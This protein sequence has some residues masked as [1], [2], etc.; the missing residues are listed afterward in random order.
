MFVNAFQ[1]NV[2]PGCGEAVGAPPLDEDG[3]DKNAGYVFC[4]EC[5]LAIIRL[6]SRN[7]YRQNR[8]TVFDHYGWLCQCCGSGD[9]LTIDHINGDGGERRKADPSEEKL[10]QK[11]ID[12]GLPEGF[13]TLCRG[14]N[15]SKLKGTTCWK[16]RIYL[17][18]DKNRHGKPIDGSTVNI[19]VTVTVNLTGWELLAA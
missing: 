1:L 7:R 12:L 15:S 3:R 17:G 18:P 10:Y 9:D 13:Q 16:H 4:R 2:C 19:N 6:D 14:C 11:L 5:G 8:T